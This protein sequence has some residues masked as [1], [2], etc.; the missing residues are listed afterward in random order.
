MTRQELQSAIIK[1][2]HT[3]SIP[4]HEKNMTV[5]ILPV[6]EM[7]KLQSTYE[8]LKAEQAKMRLLNKRTESLK[9]KKKRIELKY[10]II[11]DKMSTK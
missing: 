2:L 10:Q 9:K 1:L 11:F 3:S 4:F 7:E 8:V 6:M 5:I